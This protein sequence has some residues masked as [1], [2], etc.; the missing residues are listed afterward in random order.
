MKT[1]K[2]STRISQLRRAEA[3]KS[4]F[5]F[6]K[7]YLSRHI[8]SMPA[9]AHK[10]IFELLEN[11]WRQRGRKLAVGAPRTF[12]KSTIIT[13]AYVIFAICFMRERFIVII[14]ETASQAE[15]F[16]EIVKKELVENELLREDFPEI[17]E[18][19]GRPKP[20]R[21][22]QRQIETR[23]KIKIIALGVQQ[24]LTGRRYGR[25]RPSLIIMDD[26]ESINKT[27]TAFS[28]EKIHEWVGK[29][30]F[31]AG[32]ELTNFLFISTM[33]HPY[34]YFS[35]FVKV[36]LWECK[37]YKAIEK[38]PTQTE[39]WSKCFNIK[40]GRDEF[41]GRRGPD[42]AK[43]YY[44][45]Q[46]EAMDEGFVSI[47]PGKWD[48]FYLMN[49]RDDDPIAFNA[50]MQNEPVDLA[51]AIFRLT[52]ETYWTKAYKTIE[53]L[54]HALGEKNLDYY[55]ACDPCVG[56]DLT[57]GDYCAIIIL[58]RDRRDGCLYVLIADIK[59]RGL[60]ETNKTI[61]SY[62][63]RFHFTGVGVEANGFQEQS[64][65]IL[66]K[67][68][69]EAYVYTPVERIKNYGEKH[70]R[71]QSLEP[72][73]INQTLKLCADH[74]LLNEQLQLFPNAKFDDGPDALEMCVRLAEEPGKIMVSIGDGRIVS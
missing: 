50:E 48:S 63:K 58:A 73:I 26:I 47:W 60:D 72:L 9:P 62:A 56:L 43:D 18:L 45:S 5:A 32:D 13:L 8:S 2:I 24:S 20:P 21:W 29:S 61:I 35:M 30:V 23:N 40:H 16:L 7:V 52:P 31:R 33:H 14:S 46:K 59:R 42:A 38:E 34:S 69:K 4:L 57:R 28:A 6:A 68:M 70:K 74:V 53:E 67:E 44:L 25:H 15:G 1:K 65:K 11:V 55:L 51:T 66:E 49:M 3:S 64:V 54:I 71:I 27:F 12:G 41:N 17:F 19:R 39:L 36:P 10:E 37:I 22:T